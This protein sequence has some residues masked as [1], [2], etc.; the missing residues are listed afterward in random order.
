MESSHPWLR[1]RSVKNC[2]RHSGALLY[3]HLSSAKKAVITRLLPAADAQESLHPSNAGPTAN[4]ITERGNPETLLPA[5]CVVV[6][7]PVYVCE[8]IL[9]EGFGASLLPF[10]TIQAL[11]VE[12]HR[13]VLPTVPEND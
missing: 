10:S 7:T 1:F 9:L 3:A 12:K 5:G 11:S 6:C 4:T 13:W 2:R 8:V